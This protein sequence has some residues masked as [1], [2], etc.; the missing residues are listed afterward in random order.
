M[1]RDDE[2]DA[3]ALRSAAWVL[4]SR[5]A[6]RTFLLRLFCAVLRRRA[7]RIER[8]VVIG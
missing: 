3:A 1:A 6:K 5:A 2:R 7:D 4:E 8:P